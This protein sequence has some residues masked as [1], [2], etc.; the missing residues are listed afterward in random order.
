[1]GL[2]ELQ[3]LG[4]GQSTGSSSSGF[5]GSLSALKNLGSQAPL[6]NQQ[7]K[8]ASYQQD[9][10]RAQQESQRANSFMGIAKNT[11]SDLKNKLFGSAKN[12]V[13]STWQAYE[14]LPSKLAEDIKSSIA[15]IQQGNISDFIGFNNG[16]GIP[17][18]GGN[19][20]KGITKMAI[21]PT[22]DIVGAI[23]AP[24]SSVVGELLGQKG[25]KL[26]NNLG[27][28][29]ADKSGITDNVAF[30]KFAMEHPNAG[31]DFQRIANIAMSGMDSGKIEP[32]RIVTEVKNLGKKFLGTAHLT[33]DIP[34][35]PKPLESRFT[36][37]EQTPL[38][39]L[40]TLGSETGGTQVT[41]AARDINQY[42]VE[43]GVEAIPK[44]QLA[45]F[46]PAS[47]I[48]QKARVSDL[49]ASDVN[50]IKLMALGKE[51]LPADITRPQI[52]FNAVE[53]FARENGDIQLLRDLGKSPF[54][55]QLSEA[56]ATLGSHGFNDNPYSPVQNF[57]TLEQVRE[58]AIERQTAQ[59]INKIKQ[60]EIGKIKSE[61]K[62][63]NTKQTWSE[64]VE[65]LRC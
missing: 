27:E 54:A 60:T 56:G 6:T 16:Q 48:E 63:I 8:I 62:K 15:N 53:A 20:G 42:L 24:V 50:R 65:S 45:T 38:E 2:K 29:I 57:K 40:K 49:L 11:F 43:Q 19:L 12:I 26:I 59:P 52:L 55:T 4:T 33:T 22:G 46:E 39:K 18:I 21:R 28:T 9:A 36:A 37:V 58:R 35:E 32:A 61:V 14:Q 41:K 64:F 3:N 34:V 51:P 44:E 5:S 17:G 47:L 10:A 31:E 13:N 25:Q 1:M 30:Q 23:Y 7:V